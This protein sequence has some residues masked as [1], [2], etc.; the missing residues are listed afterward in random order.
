MTAAAATRA[1]NMQ[2]PGVASAEDT[3]HLDARSAATCRSPAGCR[4]TD[5]DRGAILLP[6]NHI[7]RPLLDHFVGAPIKRW[8]HLKAERLLGLEI[9]HHLRRDS[10]DVRWP[11]LT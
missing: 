9:Q 8:R 6:C 5:D 11:C 10:Q 4:R 7:A 1:G 2:F 3:R